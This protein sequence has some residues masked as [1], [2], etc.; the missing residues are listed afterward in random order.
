MKLI[1]TRHGQTEENKAK[2]LQGHIPGVLSEKG[3]D[4]AR[5]VAK[6]LESE[7]IDYIYASDLARAADTATEI[8]KSHPH[9]PLEFVKEL[10]E[11]NMGELQGKE[12]P[13]DMDKERYKKGYFK[14]HGGEEY[15]EL[16]LRTKKFIETLTP[17][18]YGK[19]VLL[20]A[21]NGTGQALISVL[22]GKGWEHIKEVGHL[23][24]T[25][26]TI[27]EF[28]ENK[29]SSMKLFNCTKHLEE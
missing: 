21:H 17:R 9:T 5:K 23:G 6:R 11:L 19:T 3:K 1:I 25:S 29:N 20:V 13:I 8:A 22:L 2:I 24:N 12:K 15:E 27:F 28:D 4:Q 26:I 18:F 10:R 7:K 16:T 14:K